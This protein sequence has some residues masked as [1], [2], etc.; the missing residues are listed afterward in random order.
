MNR[1]IITDDLCDTVFFSSLLN[2]KTTRDTYHLTEK[3]LKGF[4]REVKATLGEKY[5]YRNLTYTNDIW[6]RDYMPVQIFEDKFWKFWY[7][8]DYLLEKEDDKKS[9]TDYKKV[10]FEGV[11]S[12][13]IDSP[14]SKIIA[15]GGNIIKCNDFIIMTNKIFKENPEFDVKDLENEIGADVVI[16]PSDPEDKFGHADGMVRYV[17]P[18]TVLLRAAQ[19]EEDK[20]FLDQIE[21]SIKDQR[22]EGIEVLRLKLPFLK[23]DD[24]S[25]RKNNWSYINFLCIGNL[26]L[27]PHLGTTDDELVME[28]FEKIY[29]NCILQPVY[30]LPIIEAGGGALNCLSWTIKSKN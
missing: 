13:F 17:K 28:Q 4:I 30:M 27:V 18:G 23:R 10:K 9:I 6:A 12:G 5:Q 15:D 1:Q 2:S 25:I 29:G 21:K 8:P 26:I 20:K 7:Y 19:D 3:D 16:I 14:E 22:G 11:T 24:D